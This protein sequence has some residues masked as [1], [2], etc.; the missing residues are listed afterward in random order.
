MNLIVSIVQKTGHKEPPIVALVCTDGQT[1]TDRDRHR[2]EKQ[3]ER[4]S[5]HVCASR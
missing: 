2:G 3:S 4:D 5:Q 1:D